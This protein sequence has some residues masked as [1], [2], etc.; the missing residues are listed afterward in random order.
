MPECPE[1]LYGCLCASSDR[2]SQEGYAFA[3]VT[4]LYAALSLFGLPWWGS[5]LQST[6][7][8]CASRLYLTLLADPASPVGTALA[9]ALV[10][11]LYAVS[12]GSVIVRQIA[13]MEQ[14]NKVLVCLLGNIHSLAGGV[15]VILVVAWARALGADFVLGM[16]VPFAASFLADAYLDHGDY[17]CGFMCCTTRLV[18]SMC[19]IVLGTVSLIRPCDAGYTE[20]P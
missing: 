5:I 16:M 8:L 3:A 11:L 1:G 12:V 2:F 14:W 10:E 18:R 6:M 20:P 15:S 7:V 13:P 9:R 4:W 19:L 17:A